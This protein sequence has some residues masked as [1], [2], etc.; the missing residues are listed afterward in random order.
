VPFKDVTALS[1]DSIL[2]LDT[3]VKIVTASTSV[4]PCS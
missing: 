3:A 4:S 2:V 1:K